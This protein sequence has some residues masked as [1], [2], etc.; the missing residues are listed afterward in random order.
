MFAR[1]QLRQIFA[2]LR[3][4]AVAADLVDAE[5]GMGAVGQP[6]RG[7]R[8]RHFLDRDAV[9][10]IA[11]AGAAIFLFHGDAVQAERA[12][13]GPEVARKLVALVDFGGARR[14]LVAREGMDGLANRIRGLA[15]IEIEHPVRVGNHGGAASG[16]SVY[17]LLPTGLLPRNAL[18]TASKRTK[19]GPARDVSGIPRLRQTPACSGTPRWNVIG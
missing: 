3:L 13:L 17:G 19:N 18:V 5:V 8:P 2:L 4:V 14:D 7:R 15:E 16:K 12:D 1:N 11:Q 6:D 10:E 9:F